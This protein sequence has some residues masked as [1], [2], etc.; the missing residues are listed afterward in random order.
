MDHQ[1]QKTHGAL[2][3]WMLIL[4]ALA[5]F[6]GVNGA[7]DWKHFSSA[8]QGYLGVSLVAG[9]LLITGGVLSLWVRPLKSWALLTGLVA[10]LALGINHTIALWLNIIPCDTPG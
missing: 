1:H 8:L 6:I 5:T 7:R 2:P 3:V 9:V 4:G 10:A